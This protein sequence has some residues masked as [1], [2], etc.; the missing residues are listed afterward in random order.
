M[1]IFM[2][3]SYFWFEFKSENS[4]RF[5]NEITFELNSKVKIYYTL[6]MKEWYF[7]LKGKL[8]LKLDNETWKYILKFQ[9]AGG[10][11]NDKSFLKIQK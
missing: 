6:K 2:Y 9:W 3:K 5:K 4:L 10:D 7:I 11:T 8:K 1:F